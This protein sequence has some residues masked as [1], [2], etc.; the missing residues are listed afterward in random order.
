MNTALSK[1]RPATDHFRVKLFGVLTLR[2]ACAPPTGAISGEQDEK[3]VTRSTLSGARTLLAYLLVFRKQ[4]HSRAALA[5][6]LWPDLPETRARH[7]LRHAIWRINRGLPGLLQTDADMVGVSPQ[8]RLW[9]DVV[10]FTD[11]IEPHLTDIANRTAPKDRHSSQARADL[12][13]AIQLYRGDLLEGFYEDWVL[14]ERDRLRE[15]YLR[16]LEHVIQ[17]KKLAGCYEEALV[18]AQT[19]SSADPWREST[20]REIM[21]LHA[22]LDRPDAA[23][24]QFDACCQI[25]IEELG[26]QPETA[27]VQLAREIAGRAGQTAIPH[28]PIDP[29]PITLL[30]VA[31]FSALPLVGR[32][33]E[34]AELVALVDA[35]CKGALGLVLVE[36]E[37]GVGK[38]RLLQEIARDAEWRGAQV[39][40]GKG[41]ELEAS[42]P[43]GLLLEALNS[44]LSPLRANQ[45]ARLLQDT[46]GEAG[47]W[48]AGESI[49]L[50]VL[51]SLLPALADTLP[52]AQVSRPAPLEPAQEH[53]RLVE[54]LS[55]L[56]SVWGWITPLVLILEDLHWASRDTLDTL[57]HLA[58]QLPT[59]CGYGATARL[60]QSGSDDTS[61]GILI[62]GSYRGEE[63]RAKPNIWEKLRELDRRG[64]HGRLVLPRL[65]AA[66]S[67]ELICRS[68]GTDQAAPLFDARLYHETD[69]NPLFMLETLRYLHGE[70]LLQRDEDGDWSTPFDETTTDY[71]ELPLSP[72][73]ERIIGRRLARLTPDL[74]L[75]LNVAAVLGNRFDFSILAAMANMDAPTALTAL[76]TLVR[77]GFVEETAQEYRFH[78]DKIRLV[79]YGDLDAK[80][81]ARLHRHTAHVIEKAYPDRVEA[82]AYHMTHGQAWD[83]AIHY[84][85]LAAEAARTAHAYAIVVEHLDTAIQLLDRANAEEK[86]YDLL[87]ARESALDI[88]GER[89]AQAADLETMLQLARGD[90]LRHAHVQ[91]RRARLMK[92]LSR[93]DEAKA[94]ARE[95]LALAKRCGCKSAQAAA[96]MILGN[97][98]LG[99][100]EQAVSY[101]RQAVGLCQE[102][103]DL[104]QKARAHCILAFILAYY[105]RYPEAWA[106]AELSLTLYERLQDKCG[107]T[108]ALV[109]L[110]VVSM[111]KGAIEEANSYYSQ[112][113]QVAREI[114]H[115]YVEA[116]A[117]GNMAEMF[118]MKGQIAQALQ[119]SG[120]ARRI[121]QAL[122]DHLQ[123]TLACMNSAYMRHY[124][125]G[126]DDTAWSDLQAGLAS[127]I[128][129]SDSARYEFLGT[130]GDIARCR[131]DLKTARAILESATTG[132]LVDAGDEGA[133]A[134]A[135]IHLVQ[136]ALDEDDPTTA[137]KH[138]ETAEAIYREAGPAGRVVKLLSLRALVL[139]A[140]GRGQAALAATSE[141]MARLE[142]GLEQAYLVPYRHSKVLFALGRTQEARAALEQAYRMLSEIL[143]G[144]S[145]EQQKM[146]WERVPEHRALLAAWQAIHPPGTTVCLPRVGAP[147]GRPLHD[148][149]WV[150]VHWTAAE[151]EDDEIQGKVIRRHRRILRLLREAEEQGAAPTVGDLATALNVSQ[152]T[153]KR[154]LSTLRR[155]GRR[156][157]TRGSRMSG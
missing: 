31:R 111:E 155:S 50:Q 71:A 11:L 142:P 114:G 90:T 103:I 123:E 52:G 24:E 89:E 116:S 84:H 130:L 99:R 105:E 19:L 141:A 43:Y 96:L 129:V 93:H 127:Y 58:E 76:N 25:L 153:I 34:R 145:A 30:D 137:L 69:G 125:L 83:R 13:R 140:L 113:L 119:H 64:L 35:A 108:Q 44:G 151:P 87:A 29:Q 37:A 91:C 26:V 7:A 45:I 32:Q 46:P 112:A 138:L 86:R 62:F 74:R 121:Y 136:L 109:T 17:M 72:A 66:A 120:E 75:I 110:G 102:E 135:H 82:L 39:L 133:S 20:H 36:G 104:P 12:H 54:A 156:T 3:T 94:A 28:L 124:L 97:V 143:N 47:P 144:L 77:R 9:T 27:T 22:L 88:L 85:Q 15:M 81:R 148:D 4:P 60:G 59:G 42:G 78:H 6:R 65:D 152:A 53:A 14:V 57:L 61:G 21:R 1:A 56:L 67:S 134:L 131:G 117:L 149:E 147:T 40:W 68:L 10:E 48:Q 5:G 41:K 63:A 150:E 55:H 51:Y 95:A 100:P 139:S 107:Q 16:A 157:S 154:D 73:I 38:T 18:A 80:E 70:G 2:M 92:N 115:R 106:E 128:E 49:W 101:L 146:S 79:V 122:G 33:S 118:W 8:A 126:D 132:A 98:S 23:L